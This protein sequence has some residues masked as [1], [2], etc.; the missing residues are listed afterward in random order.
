VGE[1]QGGEEI[2]ANPFSVPAGVLTD[3]SFFISGSKT[4]GNENGVIGDNRKLRR[5]QEAAL[6][7]K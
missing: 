4:V 1:N 6:S 7:R 2:I 3:S 5:K